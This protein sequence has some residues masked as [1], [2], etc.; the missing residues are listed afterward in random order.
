[1]DE[2]NNI[3]KKH[4]P[5][6]QSKHK[7]QQ[8]IKAIL[9]NTHI[10]YERLPMLDVVFE[11]LV[12]MLSSSLRSFTSDNAE[13]SCVSIKSMQFVDYIGSVSS[14]SMLIIF[15]AN[16]WDNQGIL[17]VDSPLIYSMVDTLLGGRKSTSTAM[18]LENRTF[19][20]IERNLV[21]RFVLLVLSNLETAFA[22]ISK[23]QFTFERLETNPRFAA[24]AKEK[25]PVIVVTLR[26]E[27]DERGGLIELILPY[28]TIEPI[29]EL[30]L[31]GFMKENFG[32]DTVW[33]QHLASHL[34]DTNV[35]LEAAVESEPLTLKDV[36]KWKKGDHVDLQASKNSLITIFCNHHPLFT[37]YIGQKDGHIAIK[38]ENDLFSD[39]K[40]E[41]ND[42]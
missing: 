37:G 6:K 39:K 42:N 14:P 25:N 15:K 31:Q 36:M 19:T 23:V 9:N 18:K 32:H 27:M 33:E 7:V 20:I 34:W 16:E 3:S 12:H 24:I 28:A 11:H 2:N 17:V 21:E 10:Y 41:N 30:L 8:G 5:V 26:V 13:V 29:R 38:I 22:P 40:E 35:V 1:M 4:D